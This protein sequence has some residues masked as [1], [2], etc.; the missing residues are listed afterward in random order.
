M[1]D[2]LICSHLRKQDWAKIGKDLLAYTITRASMY[3]WRSGSPIELVGHTT[4]HD[5]VSAV[6]VKTLQGRR[7]WDPQ[8]GDLVPW[9][10][11][12][13]DSELDHLV[14]SASHRH[15]QP[16]VAHDRDQ[17]SDP[18]DDDRQAEYADGET[19]EPESALL[20][21]EQIRL[22]FD[23]VARAVG[24]DLALNELVNAMM[25]G[26]TDVPVLAQR[27]QVPVSEVY[28]RR[29]RLTRRL[30]RLERTPS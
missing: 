9:L 12:Q 2:N 15:E 4:A 16:M 24:D 14:R 26:T 21:K 23:A 27:L 28:T 3:S 17:N 7:S 11:W 19:L 29:R 8:R 30:S 1:T 22:D 25:D 20:R 5:I 13:I 6:I 10:K 18:E